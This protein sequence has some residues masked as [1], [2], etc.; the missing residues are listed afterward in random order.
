MNETS[1]LKIAIMGIADRFNK[2]IP[3]MLQMGIVEDL[4][5]KKLVL[6]ERGGAS[7]TVTINPDG[8]TVS[9]GSDPFSHAWLC[10]TRE[11]WQ[12]ILA[13]EKTYATIFRFELEP[14]RD[15]VPLNEQP[16]VERFCTIMQAM[17]S[18]HV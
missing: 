18:L 7:Y 16:L 4:L 2:L 9:D 17:T 6:S 12:K 1:S 14:E 5:H 10:T 3:I 13:G 15:P 8:M 11:Q